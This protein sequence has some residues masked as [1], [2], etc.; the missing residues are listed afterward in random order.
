MKTMRQ[1]MLKDT[2]YEEILHD[3]Y[4]KCEDDLIT[5][6]DGLDY[7]VEEWLDALSGFKTMTPI[8]PAS[9]VLMSIISCRYAL[10]EFWKPE[11]ERTVT[12]IEAMR[13]IRELKQEFM[14]LAKAYSREQVLANWYLDL[15]LKI[16][17]SFKH[18]HMKRIQREKGE[19]WLDGGLTK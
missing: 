9:E 15:P 19:F 2:P 16:Q 13:T 8:Q 14:K 4:P 10:I 18:I 11:E 5:F 6:L 3:D 1:L 12:Y 7:V 17:A